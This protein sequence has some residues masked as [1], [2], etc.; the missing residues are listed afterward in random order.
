MRADTGFRPYNMI[1]IQVP[2][3]FRMES[4]TRANAPMRLANS[5]FKAVTHKIL[6]FVGC[7]FVVRCKLP[8]CSP[9]SMAVF[10]PARHHR[11]FACH[12]RGRFAKVAWIF[13]G[14]ALGRGQVMPRAN[15][16]SCCCF[17]FNL[18][19][20]V[21]VADNICIPSR[22]FLNDGYLFRGA[23]Q[24]ARHAYLNFTPFVTFNRARR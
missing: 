14:V 23:L 3:P 9:S 24:W 2:K 10:H 5:R 7:S 22:D 17:Q 4:L 13:D 19:H 21:E 1:P 11:L 20:G 18:R 15:V 12:F 16:D 6:A 8:P